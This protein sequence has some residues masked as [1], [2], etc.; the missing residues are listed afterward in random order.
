MNSETFYDQ[1]T[2]RFIADYLNANARIVSAIQML[3][4][5]LP[6]NPRNILDIGCGIGW[7]THEVSIHYPE[8]TVQGIDLSSNSIAVAN[9]L[10]K[11]NNNSFAKK[12]VT[13][14]S[15]SEN[16][17]FDAIIMIDVLEH[18]PS[19]KRN[20]FIAAID[21]ILLTSGRFIVTCPS[22][23]FQ[24]Y[25]REKGEGLQPVDEDITQEILLEIAEQL[26]G[27]LIYF[28][29]VSIWQTNDYFHAVIEK[30]IKLENSVFNNTRK[31]E[32]ET[33]VSKIERI[34]NSQFH[35][36]FSPSE[37]TMYKPS[38]AK[39]CFSYIKNKF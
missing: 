22:I 38:F 3:I 25:L 34:K 24:N 13:K 32:L 39:R 8:S 37:L 14:D 33:K 27:E 21:K 9:S 30:T 4:R 6:L 12:D 10:F 15:F 28:N 18:I 29:Y 5:Q 2:K 1:S 11:R 16:D 31:V 17:Y 19:S 7:S 20:N 23:H 26:G 36:L 35:E